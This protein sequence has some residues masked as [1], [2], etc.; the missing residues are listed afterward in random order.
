MMVS[1]ME[2]VIS[3]SALIVVVLLLRGLLGKRISAGLRYGLW[4]VVLIRLL[5][6]VSLAVTVPQLPKWTPPEVMQ[7]D[8]VYVLPVSSLP[9]ESSGVYV[10]EDGSLGD[11]N[12][13]G[14]PRLTSDGE[15]VV[16]YADKITPLELLKWVWIIGAAALG[17]VLAVFNLRFSRRLRRVRRPLEGSNAPIPIYAAPALPSPCLVGLFFPAVYVTEEA[18][19]NPA[20]LRHVLAH[21]LTHYN[22]L[23]HLWSVLRG[24]ALAVHWWN[25]LVWLAV[26]CSRRDGELACDEGALKQ[27]GDSERAAYG[28]TLLSLVTAKVRPA[29]LLSFT[30]TMSGGKRSLRERIQRIAHQPRQLASAVVA[31]VIVLSLSVLVAFGQ[32]KEPEAHPGEDRLPSEAAPV[33]TA[34][35]NDWQNAEITVDESGIAHIRYPLQDGVRDLSSRPIPAPQE[36]MEPGSLES[37]KGAAALQYS[38]DIWAR[39]V[40]ETDGWLV[41]CYERGVA[42]ADTYVY[43]TEDGGLNWTE[44]TMPGTS[45]HIADVGFLSPERLIVAQRLFDGAPCFIT[46]DG[47]ETWEEI[48]LPDVQVLSIGS[49]ADTVYMDI[50]VHEGDPATFTMTSFDMGDNWTVSSPAGLRRYILTDLDH[51]GLTD[52]L[53]LRQTE[54]SGFTLWELKFTASYMSSP[55]WE[56]EAIEHHTG[57]TSFFLCHMNG[58]EYLL[59]YTPYMSTGNGYYSYKLFYL[60]A[61][62]GEV[63]IQENSVEFDINFDLDSHQFYPE[64]ISAF[65]EEI[66]A[67]LAQSE[68]LVNT[69]ENL[70]GT[71]QKEGRLYDSLW[72]LDDI[73]NDSLTLLDALRNYAKFAGGYPDENAA[74]PEMD[75]DHDGKPDELVLRTE[76][77]PLGWSYDGTVWTLQC[78]LSGGGTWEIEGK[79][80]LPGENAVFLYRM[81][82]EDYLLVYTPY[83][84]HGQGYYD[85]RLIWLDG[86]RE[87][88]VQ[89]NSV[90]FSV[91]FRTYPELEE[92]GFE[93]EAIAAFMDE[94]NALLAGSVQL[95]NTN[96]YL[97]QVFT[98]HGRLYDDLYWLDDKWREDGLTMLEILQNYGSYFGDHP[99]SAWSMLADLLE[100]L[101]EED[102]PM[103]DGDTA[104]LVRLLR[105][106]ERGSR[107][108]TWSSEADAYVGNGAEEED[109]TIW[110]LPLADGSTLWL[111]ACEE[112]PSVLMIYETPEETVSAF[113]TAPELKNLILSND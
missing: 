9:L 44:V 36:W 16:R 74:F 39:L 96:I 18:A 37:R 63:V 3:A 85:Y 56:G 108:Y 87:V 54:D 15:R 93:P 61:S 40:S 50:G 111:L 65:M 106:A 51:D 41:A 27:L 113:Y 70:I 92:P 35:P 69:D 32:A 38:P 110:N 105:S 109:Y 76:P 26:V 14:Y 5:V 75:L 82:G 21:E 98:G 8:S 6:P 80:S 81:D 62:G 79:P 1:F 48:E 45:W 64:T 97:E 90:D 30:T 22:H 89:E 112:K 73:R 60:T 100:G 94:V 83:F 77:D 104:E 88:V 42:A 20:M 53:Q 11:S 7:E 19:A 55:T 67:L 28:E 68:L 103:F 33:D 25:P 86:S 107:F 34:A 24:V 12:S 72:W 31:V 58:E 29:D 52:S 59:Q 23:D 78:D 13:F 102:V 91:R 43:K 4:A 66:N 95:V 2:W 57:W 49:I 99:D 71:F 84:W 46:K 10:T 17:I 47:G 101:T